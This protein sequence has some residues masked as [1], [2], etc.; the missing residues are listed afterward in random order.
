MILNAKGSFVLLRHVRILHASSSVKLRR[1]TDIAAER[2]RILLGTQLTD[3]RPSKEQRRLDQLY[4]V[5]TS[6]L[7]IVE[8]NGSKLF[9][10]VFDEE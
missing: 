5:I 6:P 1:H 2:S 7:S 8:K 9:E 3:M 10:S 4:S